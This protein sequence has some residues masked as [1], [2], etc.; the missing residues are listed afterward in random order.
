MVDKVVVPGLADAGGDDDGAVPLG[1]TGCSEQWDLVA[2]EWDAGKAL[3]GVEPRFE[4][5]VDFRVC[6]FGSGRG[7]GRGGGWGGVMSTL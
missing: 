3:P 6:E 4:P 1:G 7:F 2:D 5:E